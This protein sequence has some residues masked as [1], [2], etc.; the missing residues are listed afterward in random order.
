MAPALIESLRMIPNYYLQYFY[1]TA[2]KLAEQE[3]WP[4]SRAEQVMQIEEELFA[5]YADWSAVNRR[6]GADA[7]RRRLPI[8]PLRRNCS[9]RITMI[10]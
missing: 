8:Q 4:P 6:K 10:R 3:A 9:M 1:A 2:H 7:A 5:Q